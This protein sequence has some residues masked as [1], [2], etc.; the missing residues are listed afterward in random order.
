[1]TLSENGY[2][3]TAIGKIFHVINGDNDPISWEYSWLQGGG[4]YGGNSAAYQNSANAPSSMRD[5]DVATKAVA[6]LAGLKNQQPFFYGVGFVRPHLPF[7]APD[8]Y[9]DLYDVSDLVAP[10]MDNENR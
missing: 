3:S 5:H 1:M 4:S 8:E 9:W 2:Y 7:V 6:K 10:E